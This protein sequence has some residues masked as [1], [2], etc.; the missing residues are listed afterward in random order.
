MTKKEAKYT[1]LK[2]ITGYL[3]LIIVV[4]VTT[5]LIY[6]QL[7]K[8][9]VND[10]EGKYQ[11]KINLIGN[12]IANLYEAESISNALMQTGK[13]NLFTY[14]V[15]IQEKTERSIDTLQSL[16]NKQSQIL[17]LDSIS[18]LLAE[19]VERLQEIIYTKQN[20]VPENFYQ[21]AIENIVTEGKSDDDTIQV[22][23]RFKSVW[24]TTYVKY[25]KKKRRRHIEYDSVKNIVKRYVIEYDTIRR[26][27]MTM[28]SNQDSVVQILKNT[29]ENVK[30]ENESV[31]STINQKEKRL[32]EQ[33][34]EISNKLK[35][36][37]KEYEKEEYISI[38]YK[39]SVKEKTM[40]RMVSIFTIMSAITLVI[41]ILFVYFI[42]KDIEKDMK[43]RQEL[44]RANEYSRQLLASREKLIQTVTHDIKSPL[45]SVMGYIELLE[46]SV[47]N[48]RQRYFLQ[49]MNG[50][51]K[52]ILQLVINLLD[53]SKLE[54]RKMLVEQVNFNPAQLIEEI[55]DTFIP[56]TDKKKLKVEREIDNSLNSTEYKGDALKIRQIITNILSNAV[57]YTLEGTITIKA[58]KSTTGNKLCLKIKDTG[59]GM[60]KEDQ[61]RIFEEFTRLQSHANIEGTG[62]G[63]T[64]TVKLIHL[65]K[66]EL[67]LDSNIGEG[68]CF[69]IKIPLLES[70]IPMEGNL[71]R[72][73]EKTYKRGED[74]RILI[75]DDDELQ[76]AL[77]SQI[78]ENYSITYQSTTNPRKVIE[79]LQQEHYDLLITDI[80][81][82]G[83]DGIGLVK[84]I[85]NNTVDSIKD[86]PVVALSAAA[87]KTYQ[88]YIEAGFTDFM[89]KVFKPEEM[90][91]MIEKTLHISVIMKDRK[92][93]IK[94][95]QINKEYSLK[96]IMMFTD[97]DNKALRDILKS[98]IDNTR[99]HVIFLKEY[100]Q[101]ENLQDITKLTHKMLPIFRQL[102]TT[103]IVM[104][105]EKL[106]HPE[107]QDIAGN[108][109]LDMTN[110]VIRQIE[111][112]VQKIEETELQV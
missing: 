110:E 76:L 87:D 109:M 65:L 17:K 15:S 26:D 42:L 93:Q 41:I 35:R 91:D 8:L 104:I 78:M 101:Q 72:K 94:I 63:L 31:K 46:H 33:S 32:I 75:V 66:G 40:H 99:K 105:L 38:A 81:M 24:D 25:E 60:S 47:I 45:S 55:I 49:N 79:L 62:L 111:V 39:R 74:I 90:L 18:I 48:E 77:T 61:K 4:A 108:R 64:I 56:E 89:P 36:I 68:S 34:N 2:V 102:E 83:I 70:K 5:I 88:E 14:Y 69:T 57:K 53:W 37:L 21:K 1:R 95:E 84:A 20:F 28:M 22:I 82:P 97:N 16:S 58:Y 19:K 59:S 43:N 100:V 98:F 27:E 71:Q 54:N 73:E 29:W 86:I 11:R 3:L 67:K 51:A 23:P 80:Q 92:Q 50:S 112:L 85:R 103:E 9:L 10:G 44:E 30:K 12:T 107:Q 7:N 52:H 106:E 13:G 6:Q 96:N